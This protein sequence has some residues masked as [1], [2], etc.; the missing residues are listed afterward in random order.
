MLSLLHLP[1]EL[2]D[3]IIA[4]VVS[5]RI[6][7]PSDTQRIRR[8]TRHWFDGGNGHHVFYP[9]S[10]RSYISPSCS[11][12]A[13]NKQLRREAIDAVN[14]CA[15]APTIA[16]AVI[17]DCWIWPS[18]DLI[19]PRLH[20]VIN[21]LDIN[22]VLANTDDYERYDSSFEIPLP[23]F[24]REFFTLLGYLS[25]V[26]VS[27][28]RHP[29]DPVQIDH[30]VHIKD[31]YIDLK[32]SRHIVGPAVFSEQEIP[33]RAVKDMSHLDHSHLKPLEIGEAKEWLERQSE[34]VEDLIKLR[35]LPANE[36]AKPLL[37]RVQNIV[38]CLDGEVHRTHQIWTYG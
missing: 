34:R 18:W 6:K 9:E 32:P 25:S 19:I 7:H 5:S 29:L 1:R 36:W 30:E 23:N 38:M 28:P 37:E 3:Q 35:C 4:T 17:D 2:R 20:S 15:L 13:V 27:G 16:I 12:F 8:P 21:R 14:R 26:L 11:L 33:V 24:H 22:L 10:P 31:L